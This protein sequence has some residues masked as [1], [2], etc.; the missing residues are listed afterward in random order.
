MAAL[1]EDHRHM[2][3][4][5]GAGALFDIALQHV[6]KARDRADGQAVGFAGEW[7]QRM[8]GAEDKGG[9]VDQVQMASLAELRFGHVGPLWSVIGRVIPYRR[10]RGNR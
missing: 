9:P 4:R 2:G 8:I 5:I 6:A 10:A 7:R 3:R 1:V